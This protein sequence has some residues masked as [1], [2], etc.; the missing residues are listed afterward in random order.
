MD[1]NIARCQLHALSP[2]GVYKLLVLQA[3]Y[4]HKEIPLLHDLI[5]HPARHIMNMSHWLTVHT[6]R[7]DTGDHRVSVGKCSQ[8]ILAHLGPACSYRHMCPEPHTS[9]NYNNKSFHLCLGQG[10]LHSPGSTS[11]LLGHRRPVE[12]ERQIQG[13]S[14]EH[15][16]KKKESMK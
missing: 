8:R 7:Y 13:Y 16:N 11:R 4:L 14:Q 6:A 12:W 1:L 3:R 5:I 9:H 15:C 10:H 2:F